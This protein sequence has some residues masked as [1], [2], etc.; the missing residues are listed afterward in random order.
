M[1]CSEVE[2]GNSTTLVYSILLN[3][4]KSML[5]MTQTLWK[6]S[7]IF[8]KDVGIIPV[9]FTVIAITFS[10]EKIGGITF[11][12]PLIHHFSPLLQTPIEKTGSKSNS[13]MSVQICCTKYDQCPPSHSKI[14]SYGQME[15]PHVSLSCSSTN[16]PKYDCRM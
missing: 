3:L 5:K 15:I 7:L 2:E 6:N 12:M 8:A 13:Y 11:V 16:M 14:F 9:N 1:T 4:T 10:E